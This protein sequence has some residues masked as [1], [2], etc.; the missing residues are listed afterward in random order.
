MSAAPDPAQLLD[1][2]LR[3]DRGRI[4]S[5]LIARVRDFQL[6]EDAL[7]DAATSALIHWAKSGAP[8]RPDA[9]LIRVAFRKAID[10]LRHANRTAAQTR[11]MTILARD[12][13]MEDPEVIP[14]ERLRLIFTCCH[15][16]LE[17]K[18]R[19]ALTLRAVAGLSTAEIAR[20]FL[21]AE[22]TMGQRIS[23]AKTRIAET[24]IAFAVP[25]PQDWEARLASVLAVLYLIF[26]AGYTAGPAEPRSLCDEAIFLARLLDQLRPGEPEVEGIL[27][28]MLLTHARR[29][30]RLGDDGASVPPSAQDRNLWDRA[31]QAEGEALVTRAL[32]R[33]RPGPYQIK[34]AIAAC[35]LA[36]DGP[37]WPQI[38]GLYQRLYVLEPTSV[39]ALNQSVALAETGALAEALSRLEALAEPLDL[40]QPFHAARAEYFSRAGRITESRAAYD[41]AIALAVSAADAAFL[42]NR[43]DRLLPQ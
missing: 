24:G 28:L 39:V 22:P 14:D 1:Q 29:A 19:V 12:E 27:A 26:N 20:A 13:A 6:A 17:P 32:G 11:A 41:R 15:P 40:Y 4:L 25:G 9:W 5:A 3:A 18:S 42:G 8:T 34:A 7:Q 35:H 2:T 23:R 16:A 43:R 10:R 37:D 38:A 33:G 36:P 31:A 30:A 21:D